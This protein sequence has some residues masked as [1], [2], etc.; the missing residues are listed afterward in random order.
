MS[1]KLQKRR[2]LF[3]IVFVSLLLCFSFGISFTMGAPSS[4]K[5]PKVEFATYL[6]GSGDELH[7]NQMDLAVSSSYNDSQGNI[8]VVGRSKS[9]DYP[10]VNALQEGVVGGA[11][12]AITKFASD[13]QTVLFSTL[14][15][16][17]QDDWATD[18]VVDSN[19]DIIL[20]G[21]SSS[22]NFPMVNAFQNVSLGGTLAHLDIVLVKISGTTHEILFSTYYGGTKD[23]WGYGITLDSNNNPIITGSTYSSN[24]AQENPIQSENF[25]GVS[26]YIAKFSSDGQELLFG[27]YYGGSSNDWGKGIICDSTDAI[28]FAGGTMST[29]FPVVDAVQAAFQG[30]MDA[31]M[32]KIA[33]NY[34]VDCATMIG[35]SGND[36]AHDIALTES[37]DIIVVG[38]CGSATFG[39]T[40]ASFV[41]KMNGK[42]DILVAQFSNTGRILKTLAVVGGSETDVAYEVKS[43]AGMIYLIGSTKLTDNF[44]DYN[45][46]TS[47]KGGLDMFL[48]GFNESLEMQFCTCFGG[49]ADELGK[50]ITLLENNEIFLL[51]ITKSDDIKTAN[52]Y[53]DEKP[54]DL[55]YDMFAIKIYLDP[56]YLPSDSKG[57]GVFSPMLLVFSVLSLGILIRETKG[58][59]K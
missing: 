16:G 55:D 30:G 33:A 8:I 1:L 12:M 11:D 13:G 46:F 53:M 9:E 24:L 2:I 18:V 14:L 31:I 47:S 28:I 25:G 6:G 3:R 17:S 4:N 21:S 58:K 15:G 57:I 38:S 59:Q 5:L 43:K 41:G 45:H 36:E 7:Q 48:M 29:D 32:V 26:A 23:D 22:S 44:P 27:T 54:G 35:T 49:S 50:S 19:D 20:V 56:K 37:E 39:A 52:A 34:S 42:E 40:P 10:Q 51:G